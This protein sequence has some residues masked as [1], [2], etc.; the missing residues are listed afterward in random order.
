VAGAAVVALEL[1]ACRVAE[2][3]W[4]TA[5][6][7]AWVLALGPGYLVA[8]DVV[9]LGL[10]ERPLLHARGRGLPALAAIVAVGLAHELGVSHVVYLHQLVEEGDVGRGVTLAVELGGRL[11]LHWALDLAIPALAPLLLLFAARA[12]G[13]GVLGATLL[14]SLG[15]CLL[16]PLGAL[17]VHT[18]WR[19]APTGEWWSMSATWAGADLALVLPLAARLGDVTLRPT[20]SPA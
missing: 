10:L 5:R 1:P 9:A 6:D 11:D 16:V 7:L 4:L 13:V 2:G 8:L 18:A 3:S 12:R 14:V 17:A 15:A 19:P 20:S